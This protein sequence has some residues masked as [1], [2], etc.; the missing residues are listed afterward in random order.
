MCN[1]FEPV[2]Q[3]KLGWLLSAES[4]TPGFYKSIETWWHNDEPIGC[5]DTGIWRLVRD[6][7]PATVVV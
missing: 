4:K 1:S 2:L 3:M 7:R 5:V 6:M